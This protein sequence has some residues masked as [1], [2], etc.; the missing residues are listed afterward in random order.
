M[1]LNTGFLKP[2]RYAP[3]LNGLRPQKALIFAVSRAVFFAA[4]L[5]APF[6]SLEPLGAG[7]KGG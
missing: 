4:R 2:I 3:A 1:G 7:G 5:L 6:G